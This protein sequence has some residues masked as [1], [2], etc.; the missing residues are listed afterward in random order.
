LSAIST[1]ET[2]FLLGWRFDP[3]APF[4]ARL[5]QQLHD[6]LDSRQIQDLLGK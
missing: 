1:I 6:N 2:N 3:T 5:D 4:A